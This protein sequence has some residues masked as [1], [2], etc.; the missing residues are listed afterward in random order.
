MKV[1]IHDNVKTTR[2]PR[3]EY[4]TNLVNDLLGRFEHAV[5]QVEITINMDGHT[6]AAETHCHVTA[7]L[8]SLG[9]VTAEAREANEHS[10]VK[11]AID[12]LTRG[13][14]KRIEKR[15]SRQKHVESVAES[16]FERATAKDK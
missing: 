3:T 16:E 10:A 2:P 7:S 12:R 13:V 11:G 15:Q 5:H 6:A 9:V 14:S 1:L 8:G 4:V